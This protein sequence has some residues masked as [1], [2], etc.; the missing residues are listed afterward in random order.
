MLQ[1]SKR[2]KRFLAFLVGFIMIVGQSSYLPL[3]KVYAGTGNSG[4][5]DYAVT[6][7][8]STDNEEGADLSSGN[9][10]GTDV[11]STEESEVADG[12]DGVNL[13]EKSELETGADTD[14]DAARGPP[15]EEI[16][17]G[18]ALEE[19]VTEEPAAKAATK[20]VKPEGTSVLT[21]S[22]DVHNTSGNSSANR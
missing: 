3:D 8:Q 22:S 21:F 20:A 5:G 4:S 17:E 1:V 12:G 10:G 2:S 9:G 18:I 6:A 11:V 7:N 19:E 14:A 15:E 13:D 16:A